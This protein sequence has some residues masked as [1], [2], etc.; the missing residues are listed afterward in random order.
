[1]FLDDAVD[2][3]L[4]RDS[5][6]DK[7]LHLIGDSLPIPIAVTGLVADSSSS[8]VGTSANPAREDH[9]HYMNDGILK[10]A[11]FSTATGELYGEWNAWTSTTFTN[12]TGGTIAG[13]WLQVGKTL[14]LHARITAGTA[15]A[16]GQCKILIPN[17]R[18]LANQDQHLHCYNNTALSSAYSA[19]SSTL[20]TFSSNTALGTNFALGADLANIRFDGFLHTN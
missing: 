6:N 10:V 4:N 12:V 17:G 13:Y 19:A 2:L 9:T 18:T 20:I 1:M 16:A 8:T 15:T 11:K 5:H 14:Y 7:T 3:S